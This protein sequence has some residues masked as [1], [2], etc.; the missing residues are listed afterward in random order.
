VLRTAATFVVSV[1]IFAFGTGAAF[2]HSCSVISKPVG[3][4][5]AGT[6]TLDLVTETFTITSLKLT[7][8]GNLRGN[9]LTVTVIGPGGVVLDVVSVFG[10]KDMPDG[11][12]ASGPGGTSCDGVGIDDLA[13]CGSG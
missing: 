11:A 3:S 4:G 2:A 9:F 13:E 1:A 8:S 12:H 10:K 5:E 7:P 6:A